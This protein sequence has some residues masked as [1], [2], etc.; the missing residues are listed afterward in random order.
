MYMPPVYRTVYRIVQEKESKAKET[1][2]MM[3]MSEM[4]YW[5]SWFCYYTVVNTLITTLSWLMLAFVIFKHSNVWLVWLVL[6]L[7]G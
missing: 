2:L 7:F 4:S 5:C 1:M 6:W 3:G